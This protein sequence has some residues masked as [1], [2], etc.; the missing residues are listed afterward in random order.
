MRSG[1]VFGASFAFVIAASGVSNAQMQSMLGL[2]VGGSI[3]YQFQ[4]VEIT[5]LGGA[6]VGDGDLDSGGSVSGELNLGYEFNPTVAA[7][8]DV[9]FT[10]FDTEGSFTSNGARFTITGD[11]GL[12]TTFVSGQYRFI[13]GPKF[14]PYLEAGLGYGAAS[15]GGGFGARGGAGVD[16]LL[17][18]RSSVFFEAKYS[19]LT[20]LENG[21]APSGAT[22]ATTTGKFDLSATEVSAGYMYRF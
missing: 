21:L 8:I 18:D 15:D 6:D 20:G 4:S 5:E 22:I 11:S 1:L 2:L 10:T 16:F 9:G 12:T 7:F 13:A 3:G 14:R 17:G 19:Y